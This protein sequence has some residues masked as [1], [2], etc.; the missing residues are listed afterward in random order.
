MNGDDAGQH[1]GIPKFPKLK[2]ALGL[3]KLFRLS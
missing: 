2:F 1:P 3:E